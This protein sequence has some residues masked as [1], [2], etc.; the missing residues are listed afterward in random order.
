MLFALALSAFAACNG[1]EPPAA[2]VDPAE[3]EICE[4]TCIPACEARE[5]G[6]DPVCGTVCGEPCP[7]G[8]Y[9][10]EAGRCQANPALAMPLPAP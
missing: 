10:T 1:S 5:C 6:I 9:C 3:A 7:A 4:E 2:P 8:E